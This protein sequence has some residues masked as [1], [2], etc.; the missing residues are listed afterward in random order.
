MESKFTIWNILRLPAYLWTWLLWNIVQRWCFDRNG[1]LKVC[2]YIDFHQP[3]PKETSY[4]RNVSATFRSRQT[5]NQVIYICI[6][7][8]IEAC[9]CLQMGLRCL[10]DGCI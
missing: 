8:R 3:I 5:L 10:E 1:C 4:T 9:G 2:G 7:C 6:G